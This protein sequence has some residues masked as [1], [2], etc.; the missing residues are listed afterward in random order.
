MPRVKRGVTTHKRHSNILARAK[1]FRNGRRTLI[2]RANEALLKAGQ[3]AYRDRRN[4]KRDL[5][6]GWIVRIN[7]AV[8]E[9]GMSYSVF[10]SGARKQGIELNR[11]M[12]SEMA[13][14]DNGSLE[15]LVKQVAKAK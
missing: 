3:F 8:R 6:R 4:K 12:L 15:A 2:K 5:R 9:H 1:G 14:N 10:M 7:A 13:L 11:K